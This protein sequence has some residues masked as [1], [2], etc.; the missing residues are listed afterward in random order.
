MV[1]N[2]EE[3]QSSPRNR[4]KFLCSYGGKILPRPSD[5]QL[6]YVGGETRVV[7]VPRSITFSELM[8]KL[9]SLFEAD[10]VL[11]YQLM[12]EDL[13]AL[14]T[15][16]CDE[17]LS[18]MLDEYDRHDIKSLA[19]STP[20]PRLRAFLF[21]AGPV[22]VPAPAPPP[23]A[24]S[25]LLEPN[26][27]EQRYV[28]AINGVVR[29]SG[30]IFTISSSCSPPMSINLDTLH[31]N[32]VRDPPPA[33]QQLNRVR[34]STGGGMPRVHS[35][36]SLL[37]L[38]NPQSHQSH[39]NHQNHLH[40]HHPQHQR[41]ARLAPAPVMTGVCMVPQPSTQNNRYYRQHNW[42]VQQEGCGGFEHVE[43]GRV[44]CSGGGMEWVSRRLP[45][46]K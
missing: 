34:S 4:V 37:N 39:Q 41:L 29:A 27:L 1:Q 3:T 31:C 18:H 14:I 42:V 11:K 40:H 2:S 44:H 21:P 20:T 24:P 46:P 13:D 35:S 10:V 30:P 5:G 12:P 22:V 32:G 43:D 7:A 8:Q 28:D 6:K 23:P 25:G 17:D 33:E 26:P 16:T 36:P 45:S 38:G 15:V 9:T 19:N